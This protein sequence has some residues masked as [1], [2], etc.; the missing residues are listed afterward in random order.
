MMVISPQTPRNNYDDAKQFQVDIMG[1]TAG[2]TSDNAP[3]AALGERKSETSKNEKPGAN[4][5]SVALLLG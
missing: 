4:P 2:L 5:A 3:P 1:K